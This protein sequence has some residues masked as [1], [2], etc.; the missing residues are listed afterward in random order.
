MYNVWATGILVAFCAA[1]SRFLE[2]VRSSVRRFPFWKLVPAAALDGLA[3]FLSSVGGPNTPGSFQ[4][5]L[6]QSSVFFTMVFSYVFLR[7]RFS[8]RQVA[9]ALL[10]VAG[11]SLAIFPKLIGSG[12]ESC[13]CSVVFTAIYFAADLPQSLSVV[14]KDFAFKKGD[15]NVFY[16]TAAVS[17][18][19]LVFTWVYLP[20]LSIPA[21]NDFDLQSIPQ[22]FSD[23]ARCFA[24]YPVPVYNQGGDV[25]GH[26]SGRTT[27]ITFVFSIA[28]FS[29]G[30]LALIVMKRG[31]ATLSVLVSAVTLP[32][33][34]FA[35]SSGAVMDLVGSEADSFSWYNFGGV[36]AVLIGFVAYAYN[37]SAPPPQ[38]NLTA[39]LVVAADGDGRGS[40]SACVLI[41]DT[42]VAGGGEALTLIRGS[43][44][45]VTAVGR[46][47]RDDEPYVLFCDEG[48]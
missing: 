38:T 13:S 14:Y 28:G 26:C 47:A 1:D 27:A 41:E 43:A 2:S 4:V 44:P 17:W 34:N 6:G 40:G 9:G 24:G 5:L 19:Q 11:A 36:F 32:L 23:G 10:V 15:L 33:A 12:G 31:S 35:F 20:L 29:Q 39:P 48:P 30:I 21:L 22:V 7:S 46:D 25:T 3:D 45:S 16:L 42:P 37:G 8:G 18:V